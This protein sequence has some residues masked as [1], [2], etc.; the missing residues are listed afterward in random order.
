MMIINKT[1]NMQRINNFK[2]SLLQ[3][4]IILI[5][6]LL[7]RSFVLPFQDYVSEFE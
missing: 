1:C 5:K 3:N 2:H 4:K 6:I 7:N